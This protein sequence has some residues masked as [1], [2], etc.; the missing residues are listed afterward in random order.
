MPLLKQERPTNKLI[1]KNTSLTGVFVMSNKIRK[2][3]FLIHEVASALCFVAVER[4]SK[5]FI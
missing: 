5:H 3:V 4:K 2:F 1:K